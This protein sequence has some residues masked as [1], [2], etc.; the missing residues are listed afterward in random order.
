MDDTYRYRQFTRSRSII[1]TMSFFAPGLG[2]LYI[3]R[4]KDAYWHFPAYLS[5][6]L[7]AASPFLHP[8]LGDIGLLVMFSGV[9]EFIVLILCCYSS[10]QVHHMVDTETRWG[11]AWSAVPYYLIA[12]GCIY[13]WFEPW[14]S[15]P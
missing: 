10:Y 9:Y 15:L 2:Q 4:L 3:G 6:A 14:E 5:V 8:D 13:L 11:I 7:L 1:A 12:L